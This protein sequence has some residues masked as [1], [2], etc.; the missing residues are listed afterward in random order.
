[1][2]QSIKEKIGSIIKSPPIKEERGVFFFIPTQINGSLVGGERDDI[3]QTIKKKTPQLYKF[4]VALINARFV[5]ERGI[6]VKKAL[7]MAFS[8]GA[9]EKRTII[10]LG[11][12]TERMKYGIINVDCYPYHGVD[13]VADAMNLPFKDGSVDMVVSIS[14]L[15]HVP[16]PEKVLAE[17]KRVLKVGWYLYCA[18]PFMYPFHSAPNDY[19][20]F[21]EGWFRYRLAHFEFICSGV[22]SGPIT[23][24]T[25]SLAYT[26]ALIF[27]FGSRL[28]YALVRDFFIVLLAPLRV[29]DFLIARLPF[30]EDV[31]ASIYFF[32]RKNNIIQK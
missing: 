17:I 12:G 18:V 10:N 11:S 14:L 32:A 23:A 25:I 16:E 3:R 1:M 28:W 26:I 20:R 21:T 2:E 27:S 29:F 9:L 5:F 15:E 19:T 22:D 6:G 24:I 13:V 4:I 31:A 7:A 30:S 8:D